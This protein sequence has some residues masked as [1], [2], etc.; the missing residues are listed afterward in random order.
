M[1]VGSPLA[2]VD[3]LGMSHHFVADAMGM[4]TH[5]TR[6]VHDNDLLGMSSHSTRSTAAAMDAL[7]FSQHSVHDNDLQPLRYFNNGVEVDV[8]GIPLPKKSSS[9]TSLIQAVQANL[10]QQRQNSSTSPSSPSLGV[11]SNIISKFLSVVVSR[12]PEIVDRQ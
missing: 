12:V 9:P 4:S 3:A 11:D 2:G 10:Q 8:D 1:S 5:S 6:S 7:A